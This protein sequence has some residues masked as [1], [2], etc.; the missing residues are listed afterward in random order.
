[1]PGDNQTG[2][3][4]KIRQMAGAS[5]GTDRV[6]MT[7]QLRVQYGKENVAGQTGDSEE[8]GSWPEWLVKKGYSLGNDGLVQAGKT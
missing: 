6:S 5:V 1:M 4:D 8:T 7:K 2:I 3:I